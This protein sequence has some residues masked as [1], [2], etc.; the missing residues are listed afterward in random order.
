MF[1]E[2]NGLTCD[3]WK[4]LNSNYTNMI[5]PGGRTFPLE[6]VIDRNG[7]VTYLSNEYYPGLAIKEAKKAL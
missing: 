5:S 6:V 4:D 1:K 3:I 2:N 7:I